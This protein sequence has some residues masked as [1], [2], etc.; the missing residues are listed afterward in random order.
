[1]G[2]TKS[3]LV[4][5]TCGP[6]HNW[7]CCSRYEGCFRHT[8]PEPRPT[9]CLTCR[10]TECSLGRGRFKVVYAPCKHRLVVFGNRVL[11]RMCGRRRDEVAGEWR[12][13]RNVE[14]HIVYSS[15]G[16]IRM[17]KLRRMRWARHVA[18][19]GQR[20]HTYRLLVGKPEG[21]SL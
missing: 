5:E 15:P 6:P 14:L 10:T 7:G 17:I 9:T 16:I 3:A 1:V 4:G 12:K 18:R 19:M 2:P 21:K 8:T 13:L 11:R 20:K